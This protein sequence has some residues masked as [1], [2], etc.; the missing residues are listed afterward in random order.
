MA[1]DSPWGWAWPFHLAWLA[2]H[3]ALPPA[4]EGNLFTCYPDA[5]IVRRFQQVDTAQEG[6]FA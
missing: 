1:M 6:T 2:G 3:K 4:L 5:A